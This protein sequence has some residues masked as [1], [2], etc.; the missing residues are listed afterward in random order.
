MGCLRS[1]CGLMSWNRL[2]NEEVRRVQVERQLSGRVDQCV[3]RWYG[4]VERMDEEC[5][6]KKGMIYDVKRNR[7]RGEPRL[8]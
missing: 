6:A 1:M 2:R 7:C 4:H 5:V 8:G 3:L